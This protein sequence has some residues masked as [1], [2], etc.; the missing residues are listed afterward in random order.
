MSRIIDFPVTI[1]NLL[2][3]KKENEFEL[4]YK[5][6]YLRYYYYAYQLTGDKDVSL[7]IVGEAFEHTW[8]QLHHTD[9]LNM[10]SF[11][12][13]LVRNKC[14]DYI[15]HETTK[16]R[17]AD[18]YRAMYSEADDEE[19]QEEAEWLTNQ[20]YKAIEGLTPQ[21]RRILEMCYYRKMSYIEISEQLGVSVSTVRKHMVRAL[22][23]LRA[24]ITK[25]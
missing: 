6:N 2:S 3:L 24:V 11:T 4:F 7:D 20:V 8:V 12:Y 21:T 25:K 5:E 13:R 23:I 18:F 15:R 22:K 17:Y 16:A 1:N 14:I 19:A 9:S 10:M